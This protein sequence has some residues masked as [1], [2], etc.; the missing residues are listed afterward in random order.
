[1]Q[2]RVAAAPWI[3]LL[4]WLNAVPCSWFAFDRGSGI[5]TLP[6][7]LCCSRED[8]V[9]WRRLRRYSQGCE[10]RFT[11]NWGW[12]DRRVLGPPCPLQNGRHPWPNSLRQMLQS[13]PW[14]MLHSTAGFLMKRQPIKINPFISYRSTSIYYIMQALSQGLYSDIRGSC[15]TTQQ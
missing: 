4:P 13:C 3:H 14:A 11:D 5:Q 2:P 1:M 6:F 9:T 7:S 8:V 15:E 10:V 12:A